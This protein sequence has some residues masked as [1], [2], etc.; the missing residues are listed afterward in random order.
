MKSATTIPSVRVVTGLEP[1]AISRMPAAELVPGMM[2]IEFNG[3]IAYASA[4][5]L[6]HV[7]AA[8]PLL[9]KSLGPSAVAAVRFWCRAIADILPEQ[10][11]DEVGR[12]TRLDQRPWES[13]SLAILQ[14]TLFVQ[15]APAADGSKA[16]HHDRCD[17]LQAVLAVTTCDSWE[18]SRAVGRVGRV[19][20]STMRQ[21][22]ATAGRKAVLEHLR[23]LSLLLHNEFTSNHTRENP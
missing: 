10:T 18:S 20:E 12:L 9:W 8:R 23:R 15:F 1:L 14:A 17:V 3:E 16:T 21:I 6:A 7:T 13:L 2:P 22:A 5:D 4:K 11:V 19:T